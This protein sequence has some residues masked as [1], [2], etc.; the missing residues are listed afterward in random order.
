MI[1]LTEPAK[2]TLTWFDCDKP[3][4]KPA[5][6]VPQSIEWH[7]PSPNK[8]CQGNCVWAEPRREERD[9]L[10]KPFCLHFEVAMYHQAACLAPMILHLFFNTSLRIHADGRLQCLPYR[11]AVCTMFANNL[12]LITGEVWPFPMM[13]TKEAGSG[14][15]LL[16]L[17]T[18]RTKQLGW[19]CE[20]MALAPVVLL[21]VEYNGREGPMWCCYT[22][23]A[24]LTNTCSRFDLGGKLSILIDSTG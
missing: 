1:S 21:G 17:N 5:S 13:G 22:D 12:C 6:I 14:A 18:P 15:F 23:W 20:T 24:L 2:I 8:E 11:Y 16:L 4:L 3:Q 7:I 19:G 9:S 10:H